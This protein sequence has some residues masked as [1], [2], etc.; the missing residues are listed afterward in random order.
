MMRCS[1]NIYRT[2]RN[3][4]GMTQEQAA[5]MLYV[6]VR[7]LAEYEAGRIIPG[8]DTVCRMIEIYNT[9]WLGYEHLRYA[10]EVGKRYL[11]CVDLTDFAKSVLRLQ[12]ETGDLENIKSEMIDIACDGRVNDHEK[13]RWE[14]VKKEIFEMAGAALAV[15][16]CQKEKPQYKRQVSTI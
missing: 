2:A 3:I 13:E 1:G 5:E 10:S 9:P 6:S 14:K 12:K 4:T 8:D 16:F 15:M 11:P 7:S